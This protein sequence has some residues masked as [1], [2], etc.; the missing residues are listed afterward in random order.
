VKSKGKTMNPLLQLKHTTAVFLIAFGLACFGLLPKLQAVLPSPT[1]DGGYPGMNTAEGQNAL[2]SLIIGTNT[3]INNTAIG[4]SSL[5]SLISG[6]NNTAI[7]AG[8]L[9]HN[10]A[11][12]NTATG[13][14]ALFFNTAGHQNT[15]DG[16]FALNHN[17]V[18]IDNTAVGASALFNNDS[19]GSRP[20]DR[21][22][23]N[24]GLRARQ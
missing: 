10:T 9:F 8:S 13:A 5:K 16:A 15:A 14:A 2:L 11:N 21:Q 19:T 7:G 24:W 18:A 6:I 4:S 12:G 22:H 1:P 23:G 3:G 20:C 17:K